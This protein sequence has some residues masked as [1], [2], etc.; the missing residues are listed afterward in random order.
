MARKK[1]HYGGGSIDPRGEGSWRLRHR[2]S[3]V[4]YT[5]TVEGT[6][7]DAARELRR[8]LHSGDTG[9]HVAPD[10]MT[11]AAWIDHWISI[12]APGKRKKKNT[13]GTVERY[14]ELL[15]CHVQPAI[16]TKA[17]QSITS[18]DIDKLYTAIEGRVS[19]QTASH[20]HR[21]FNA[22]LG[23]AV[24]TRALA[25]NPIERAERIP[26][27]GEGNH[28][29]ALDDD[30]LRTLV[31]GFQK[32]VLF[33]VYVLAFTGCRRNEALAL[34]WTDLD[35]ANKTLR[36]ER[37]IEE[38]KANGLRFKGPKK[39]A[40]KR[41]ITIDDDLITVLVAVREKHQRLVAGIP[42]RAG[43]VDL[44]LVKLPDDALMFPTPQA[45]GTPSPLSA[46]RD[47][48]NTSKEIIRK[49]RALGFKGLRVHDLRGSHETCLLDAGVPCHVVAARC[50]HDPAVLL[51][52]YAKRTRKADVSA[53]DA[54]ATLSKG[55]LTG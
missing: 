14:A 15:R 38:T 53:A 6:K 7:T 47:P 39:E 9:Q 23:A 29:M 10:K 35:V 20:V 36:I 26:S 52:I 37:A 24:R 50:G 45:L 1:G 42:D 3:G 8:L 48:R 5:K 22:C 12:G 19:G 17:L 43:E 11:V 41:S 16:G 27:A 13:D 21:V 31:R 51:R 28:G 18:S 30:Q 54:I 4:R 2:I 40:H 44:S 49:A 34:R 32:S 55:V 25:V 46:P 33:P